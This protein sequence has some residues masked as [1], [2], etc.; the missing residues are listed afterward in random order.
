M[1]GN[2]AEVGWTSHEGHTEALTGSGSGHVSVTT[3]TGRS[4]V[5]T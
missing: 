1:T 2:V 5:G 4:I 3:S